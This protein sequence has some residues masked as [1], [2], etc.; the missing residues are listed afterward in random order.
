MIFYA[1]INDAFHNPD[2]HRLGYINS[3]CSGG[4]EIWY[5]RPEWFRTG[6]MGDPPLPGNLEATHILL[7]SV[8]EKTLE[9]IWQMMQGDVWSPNGEAWRLI[10]SKGLRHT[11]MS[12]GDVV[13]MRGTAHV[14]N[15]VGF[16]ELT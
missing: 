12:V 16:K 8:L 7:G 9:H 10:K 15:V 2:V 6:I 5:M 4:N 1:T 14:A 3:F 11:S 13:V